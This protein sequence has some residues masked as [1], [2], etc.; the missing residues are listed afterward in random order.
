M[1]TYVYVTATGA[2]YSYNPDDA[3]P[4]ADAATLAKNGLTAVSGL[5]ALD[6]THEWDAASKSVVV[7]AEPVP[8]QPIPTG[9]WI[10]RF[11]PAEFQAIAASTDATVQQF[12]YALNHT[13]QIDLTDQSIV[14]GVSYLVSKGL[15][16]Q[17]RV[18]A[19]MAAP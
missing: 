10:L 19:V 7:V 1:A 13:T 14:N 16:T 2:L 6:A 15:L 9:T 8:P 17:T 4:V 3:S 12:M 5:A 18:A 11:T